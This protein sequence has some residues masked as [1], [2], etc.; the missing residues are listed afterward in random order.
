MINDLGTAVTQSGSGVLQENTGLSRYRVRT[1]VDQLLNEGRLAKMPI[2]VSAINTL[3]RRQS[4]ASGV[5][6]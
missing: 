4:S 5:S 2:S 6:H 1:S 3:L